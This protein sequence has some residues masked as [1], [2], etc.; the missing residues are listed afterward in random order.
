M[1]HRQSLRF[2]KNPK[3]KTQEEETVERLLEIFTM[4]GLFKDRF[5]FLGYLAVA[6]AAQKTTRCQGDMKFSSATMIVSNAKLTN[7]SL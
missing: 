1:G 6:M 7:G 5:D 3:D 2:I 4:E